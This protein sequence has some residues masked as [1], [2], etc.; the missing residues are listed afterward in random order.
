[1]KSILITIYSRK[2]SL[3]YQILINT[4]ENEDL[5]YVVYNQACLI[6][7]ENL[8]DPCDFANRLNTPT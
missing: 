3:L 7:G 4:K 8:E 1:M 2:S 5:V 6:E